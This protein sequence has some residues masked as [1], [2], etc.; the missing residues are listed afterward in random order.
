[1]TTDFA[2]HRE[3]G[4]FL[5]DWNRVLPSGYCPP[6]GGILELRDSGEMT[7]FLELGE[8]LALGFDAAWKSYVQEFVEAGWQPGHPAG[9]LGLWSLETG[10][11]LLRL[12]GF[13][14]GRILG[15]ERLDAGRLMTWGRDHLI[16]V[17]DRETGVLLEMLP[18]PL[19]SDAEGTAFLSCEEFGGLTPEERGRYVALRDR[20]APRVT[21]TWIVHPGRE[22]R[23]L[24]IDPVAGSPE[25]AGPSSWLPS[26]DPCRT[27]PRHLRDMQGA[28]VGYSTCL[29]LAD[30]RVVAGGTT[31]GSSG[32]VYVWDGLHDLMVLHPGRHSVNFEITG[33][34]EP[35]VVTTSE[36]TGLDAV[37]VYRFW[38]QRRP[39]T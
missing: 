15:A 17:W 39:R 38:V 12:Q 10:E 2:R 11:P 28:E 4:R 14:L 35:G 31:Y 6:D 29:V 37:D 19:W 32:T 34:T 7:G 24:R 27:F 30:G 1:M 8:G 36:R 16:R 18:L 23:W 9:A 33:E 13:H 26:P 21:H 25:S 5:L 20:P 3:D 22:Q